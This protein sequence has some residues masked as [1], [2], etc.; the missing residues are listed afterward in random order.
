[1]GELEAALKELNRL[2]RNN[3]LPATTA[4]KPDELLSEYLAVLQGNRLSMMLT[5]DRDEE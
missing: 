5:A 3:D 2:L 4:Q 1:M